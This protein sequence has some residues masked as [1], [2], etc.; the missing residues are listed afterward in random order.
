MGLMSKGYVIAH[1]SFLSEAAYEIFYQKGFIFSKLAGVLLGFLKRIIHLF[2][3]LKYDYVFVYRELTPIGPPVFEWLLT[4]IFL[5]KLIYDFDDAIWLLSTSS[6]NRIVGLLR[7]SAKVGKICA[8]SY[9]ISAGNQFLGDYA[10][11]YCKNISVIPTSIDLMRQGG[12]TKIHRAETVPVIGWTGSHSTVPFL[13]QMDRVLLPMM[14]SGRARLLVICNKKP[15]LSFP[16]EYIAWKEQTEVDDLLNIDIGIM[17]LPNTE[18]SKGKCGFK[19]LQYMSL[20]IPAVVSPV[21]VNSKII[22]HF[23]N[24][25]LCEND[26]DWIN[27][28]EMLINDHELRST[29][30]HQG[31]ETVKRHYSAEVV[32]K[33]YKELFG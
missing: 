11:T 31:Y 18:W 14:E 27:T 25:Y 9:K 7:N 10:A 20:R 1:R 32:H 13:E 26:E 15:H 29:V 33:K 19:A 16:F 28:L 30:G 3:S 23:E 8:W 4:K 21:G 12:R 2:E 24:G 17:P 6:E 22:N 5:K